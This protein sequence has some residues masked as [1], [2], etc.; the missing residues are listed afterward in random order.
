M[1][2]SVNLTRNRDLGGPT[3]SIRFSQPPFTIEIADEP[4]LFQRSKKLSR[5]YVDFNNQSCSLNR[6]QAIK[7]KYNKFFSKQSS[8]GLTTAATSTAPWYYT[9]TN[10]PKVRSTKIS[11]AASANAAGVR[12]D[13]ETFKPKFHNLDQ[14]VDSLMGTQPR[15]SLKS[16]EFGSRRGTLKTR[17]VLIHVQEM[18]FPDEG[19]EPVLD[20]DIRIHLNPSIPQS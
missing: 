11:R 5:H 12:Y 20:A 7:G 8:K 13:P 4:S 17:K 16:S 19:D 6:S 15:S 3:D 14:A 1:S 2:K 9:Q 18:C 10:S